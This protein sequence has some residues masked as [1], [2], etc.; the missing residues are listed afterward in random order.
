M[1]GKCC[2]MVMKIN[3]DCHGCYRKVR[4]VLLNIHELETHLVEKEC[5]VS[6]CGK[7]IP[8]DMAIKIRK[9]INRRVEII[10]IQELSANSETRD[11]SVKIS[12]AL[13]LR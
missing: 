9:K 10:R 3:I 7:F 13:I 6:I 11:Q 4:R 8:Q 12:N 2:C 5:R 1:T